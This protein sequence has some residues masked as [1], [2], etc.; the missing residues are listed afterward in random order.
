[1]AQGGELRSVR[2]AKTNADVYRVLVWKTTFKSG[3]LSNVK[4]DMHITL[5]SKWQIVR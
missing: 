1:M 3:T 2:L 5:G 4:P